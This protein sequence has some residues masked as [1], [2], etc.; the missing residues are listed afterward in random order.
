MTWLN[1]QKV[2]GGDFCSNKE[3][4]FIAERQHRFSCVR[5]GVSSLSRRSA[6]GEVSLGS[7]M[8]ILKEFQ[9]VNAAWDSDS[10]VETSDL[11]YKVAR[12]SRSCMHNTCN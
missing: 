2:D 12:T 11:R 7:E 9:A 4:R 3:W 10:S 5:A 6:A 8:E 1:A